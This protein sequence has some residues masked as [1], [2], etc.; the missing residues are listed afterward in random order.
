MQPHDT[1]AH[2]SAAAL[3]PVLSQPLPRPQAKVFAKVSAVLWLGNVTMRPDGDD[4][5]TVV[6]DDAFE[7]VASLLGVTPAALTFALTHKLVMLQAERIETSLSYKKAIDARDALAKVL[8][9]SV[10]SFIVQ[11]INEVLATDKK[12]TGKFIA[13]LD[14]YGFESFERNHFEQLC[15]NYANERL[16][17]QFNRHLFKLEQEL[18]ESEGIDWRHIEFVDNQVRG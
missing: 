18:Y 16:Q 12:L 13:I 14:I 4:H 9:A 8:Y 2:P 1:T 6:V 10:F 5:T 11:K 7:R 15:I 17:Q 3:R